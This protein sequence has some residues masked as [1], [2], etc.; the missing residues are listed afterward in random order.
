MVRMAQEIQ[1]VDDIKHV[2]AGW[3][4]RMHSTFLSKLDEAKSQIHADDSAA[5]NLGTSNA[6]LSALGDEFSRRILLSAIASGKT[7][8]EVSAEQNLPLSTCYRRIR[9]FVDE[10]LMILERIVVSTT[11]KKYA[12]YRTSFS[13]AVV[14]FNGGEVSIDIIPNA[15]V[16]DKL[17]SRWLSTNYSQ[18]SQDDGLRKRAGECRNPAQQL[19]N[20]FE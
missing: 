12:I 4:G 2:A 19:S 17:H 20:P 9:Q 7:V 16:L 3:G 15:D 6:I 14:R 11:G 8:E 18:T 1:R 13:E 10:G 5:Q